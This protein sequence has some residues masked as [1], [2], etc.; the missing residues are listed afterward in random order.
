[1]KYHKIH[2]VALE[3]CTKEQKI[4]YNIAF[5]LH[6]SAGDKYHKAANTVP[7]FVLDRMKNELLRDGLRM[8]QIDGDPRLDVDAIF[9]AL[10]A[11][12]HDYLMRPFV[13]SSYEQVGK[14]FPANY[15]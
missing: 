12:L 6:I 13:A 2:G 15:L 8:W 3:T 5:R 10:R 14:A 7:A 1:M 11:G 4:A 9:S